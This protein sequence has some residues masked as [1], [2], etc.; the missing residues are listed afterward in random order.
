MQITREKM[1][2]NFVCC[3]LIK[4]DIV[5]RKRLEVLSE[6]TKR[7][8]L[9]SKNRWRESKPRKRKGKQGRRKEGLEACAQRIRRDLVSEERASA[10]LSR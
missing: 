8:N 4:I 10:V 1:L 5:T 2:S 7:K 6:R 9:L 3:K